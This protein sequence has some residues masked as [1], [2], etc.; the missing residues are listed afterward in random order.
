MGMRSDRKEWNE[1]Y[2]DV[3]AHEVAGREGEVEQSV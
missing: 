2:M 3:K 1:G